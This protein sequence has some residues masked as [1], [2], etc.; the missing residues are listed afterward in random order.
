MP[1]PNHLKNKYQHFTKASLDKICNEVGEY[2]FAP[3]EESV[4]DYADYLFN[5]NQS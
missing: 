3:F 5:K 1:F 2:Q 4:K